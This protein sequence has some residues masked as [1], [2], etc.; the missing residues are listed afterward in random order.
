MLLSDKYIKNIPPYNSSLKRFTPNISNS[1]YT[2]IN[3]S[4]TRAHCAIGTRAYSIKDPK[5][6]IFFTLTNVLGGPAM[7]SRLNMALREKRGYVY[8]IEA[9]YT[10]YTDTGSIAIFFGTEYKL[11]E[12]SINLVIKEIDS[13][14]LSKISSFHIQ[15]I[16]SQIMGQLAMAEENNNSLMLMMGRS[17]LDLDRIDTL[18]EIFNQIRNITPSKLQ[19][20]ANEIFVKDNL[21]C[22][23]FIPNNYGNHK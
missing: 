20:V 3:K 12:R 13:I 22:L 23:N 19:D 14:K 21:C 15:R 6:I 7:N 9:N 10:P 8:S 16:H 5:R 2:N 11:L 18:E 1:T 4:I 17:M